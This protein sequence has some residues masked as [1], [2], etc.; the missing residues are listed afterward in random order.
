[1]SPRWRMACAGVALAPGSLACAVA[2]SNAFGAMQPDNVRAA[3][4]QAMQRRSAPP[5]R[6]RVVT[7]RESVDHSNRR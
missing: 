3:A 2:A 7:A 6:L 5:G 4:K 1:M